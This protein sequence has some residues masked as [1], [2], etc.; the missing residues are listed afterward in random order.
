V[1]AAI[2]GL[3]K[4]EYLTAANG[5]EALQIYQTDPLTIKLVFMGAYSFSLMKLSALVLST[6]A[7]AYR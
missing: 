4:Q 1:D 5:L 6:D 7:Y 3:T 2:S